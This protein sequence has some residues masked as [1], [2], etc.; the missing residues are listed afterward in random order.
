MSAHNFDELAEHVGH[1]VEVT[2]YGNPTL[3]VA[4]ECIDCCMVLFDFDRGDA[5]EAV[6]HAMKEEGR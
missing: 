4:V 1:A 5:M 2:A 6:L 3:N